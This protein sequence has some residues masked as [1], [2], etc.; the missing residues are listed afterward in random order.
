MAHIPQP[1]TAEDVKGF[2]FVGAFFGAVLLPTFIAIGKNLRQ[3]GAKD[4]PERETQ[5]RSALIRHTNNLS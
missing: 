3:R 1:I 2:L 4:E 5:Y